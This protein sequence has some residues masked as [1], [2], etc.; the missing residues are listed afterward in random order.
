MT[1]ILSRLQNEPEE[2]RLTYTNSVSLLMLAVQPGT[3]CAVIYSDATVALLLGSK[4]AEAA[5]MFAWLGIA[6]LHQTFT[7]TMG[8]LF[9]SQGRIRDLGIVGLVNSTS[10]I[11]SFAVGLP[12]GPLG[13]AISYVVSDYALRLPFSW[14]MTGR[15]GYVGARDIYR[16]VTPHACGLLVSASALVLIKAYMEAPSPVELGGVLVV[17]YAINSAVLMLFKPKRLLMV[18]VLKVA[19]RIVTLRRIT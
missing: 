14:Y 18:Q 7:S 3:L 1:P 10:T 2:Y 12:W 13:V 4:W 8:W 6:G 5:P 16:L 11:A 17:S 9:I 15:A 19:C